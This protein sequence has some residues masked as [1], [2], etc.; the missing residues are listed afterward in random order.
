MNR[1]KNYDAIVGWANGKEIQIFD[2]IKNEWVDAPLSKDFTWFDDR[3]YRVKPQMITK[4]LKLWYDDFAGLCI[5]TTNSENY[6]LKIS[7]DPSTFEIVSVKS[8]V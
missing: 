2:S 8:R 6:Q 3:E 4:Y 5:D 7:I 1:N